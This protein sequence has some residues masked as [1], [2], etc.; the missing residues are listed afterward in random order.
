[1]HMWLQEHFQGVAPFE[2]TVYNPVTYGLRSFG[3]N[4][5]RTGKEWLMLFANIQTDEIVWMP[6]HWRLSRFIMHSTSKTYVFLP[7]LHYSSFYLGNRITRQFGRAP[8]V[9]IWEH[10]LPSKE[11]MQQALAAN[12]REYWNCNIHARSIPAGDPPESI[13]L[14]EAYLGWLIPQVEREYFHIVTFLSAVLDGLIAN[15]AEDRL[16]EAK[17]PVHWSNNTSPEIDPIHAYLPDEPFEVNYHNPSEASSSQ[18]CKGEGKKK[19][20][21]FRFW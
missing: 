12:I 4:F 9:P 16:R 7:G 10:N 11:V 1:M 6:P 21:G 13:F 2:G 17:P 3:P 8:R 15:A 14:D 5:N 19:G 20:K 18:G